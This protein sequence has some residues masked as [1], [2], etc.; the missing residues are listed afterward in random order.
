MSAIHLA[1]NM[2]TLRSVKGGCYCKLSFPEQAQ[3]KDEK[4]DT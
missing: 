1:D 2:K 3:R 4:G